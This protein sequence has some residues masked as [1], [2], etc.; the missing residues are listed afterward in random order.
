M[1]KTAVFILILL[2]VNVLKSQEVMLPLSVN[3]HLKKILRNS[4]TV[5]PVKRLAAPLQLPFFDDFSNYTG[6]PDTNKWADNQAFANVDYG[7]FPPTVGVAT[8]DAIDGNGNLYAGVSTTHSS[9]DTLTSLPIRLDS[10]FVPYPRK[11]TVEDS[12]Y[13]SFYCQPGGGY[14]NVWEHIGSAPSE[15]DSLILE[16]YNNATGKWDM[17]WATGGFPLD[18]FYARENTFFKFVAVPVAQQEY[19]NRNFKFRFRNCVSFDDISKPG[20][21]G[22]CDN[23]NIDYVWLDHS[24]NSRQ[25]SRDV[26]FVKKA[27]S[28]LAKYQAMPAKQF[29]ISD[30]KQSLEM[31]ITNLYSQPLASTYRYVVRDGTG[32]SV[33]GYNGGIDN[34]PTYLPNHVYQTVASHANPP[35]TCQFQV[36]PYEKNVFTVIHTIKEGYSGDSHTEN[37]TTAFVQVFDNYY[38]YDDGTPENGYGVTTTGSQCQIACRYRLAVPD[39][40]TAV[41]I[42]FNSTKNNENLSV[43]F[44]ICVWS[45]NGGYPGN[46]IYR[47]QEYVHPVLADMNQYYRYVL[48]GSVVVRG[49]VYI[50]IEQHSRNYINMGFDR[51]TDSH[52]EIYYNAANSWQQSVLHGSLM[53]RPYFGQKAVVGL[54]GVEKPAP[55]IKIF[56]NPCGNYF[57]AGLPEENRVAWFEIYDMFGKMCLKNAIQP[58][59][60]VSGLKAGVYM[61]RFF[62][63]CGQVVGTQKMIKTK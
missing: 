41:D 40:L 3:P 53:M 38:A 19:L 13:L 20:L 10:A 11:L 32:D 37:D 14:G 62:D 46:R 58:Q 59:N 30:M 21:A 17:V 15:E 2:T 36:N 5:A 49:T 45:D 50:G 7:V 18:T 16:F 47:S 25:Y 28:M 1:K 60:S 33:C 24:R 34:A 48:D 57:V 63:D 43:P 8:L 54:N 29:Q 39:T 61:V 31:T 52:E 42:Y 12:I 4:Q 51:N 44:Y 27:P 55:L 6:Y 35:V 9:G 26:A 56:P 23:W 22:N